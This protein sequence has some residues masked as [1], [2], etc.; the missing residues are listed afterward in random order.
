MYSC[1]ISIAKIDFLFVR[2][3]NDFG[4]AC[5][6]GPAYFINLEPS[7]MVGGSLSCLLSQASC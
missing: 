4:L 5:I 2:G 7:G 3:I 6:A 1:L